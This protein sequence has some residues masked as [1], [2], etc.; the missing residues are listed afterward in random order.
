MS[1]GWDPDG[2][3]RV[4]AEAERTGVSYLRLELASAGLALE[5][6]RAGAGSI[7]DR[8]RPVIEAPSNETEIVAPVLG[9]FY[10]RQSP[11]NPPLVEVGD[12]VEAGALL[13]LIEVMK[14]YHEVTAPV[15]GTIAS[16]LAE[17]GHYVEYGQPL[18]RLSP[19]S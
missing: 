12:T 7:G 13:G 16:V 11:E 6:S 3:I 4:I 17:D 5:I 8:E 9:T 10:R 19:A 18:F 14:T 1:N 2:V 15:A